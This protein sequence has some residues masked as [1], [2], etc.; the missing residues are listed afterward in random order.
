MIKQATPDNI[1]EATHLLQKGELV[2]FPT[3]TV[4]GL[5]ADATSDQAVEK[6]YAVKNRPRDKAFAIMVHDL[7]QARSLAVFD[8][9]A[10]TLAQV[11]WPG[12]LS[13]VLPIKENSGLSKTAL[14]GNDTIS[15][16]MPKHR[17]AL[18]LL[19]AC[20]TPLAVPSA[21]SSGHLS[22]TTALDVARDLGDKVG[23]IL[24]DA[25]PVIGIESTIID[26]TR[27][28]AV[29]LRLG[30]V[31]AEEIANLIGE[32]IIAD[33]SQNTSIRLKTELRLKAVDVKPGEAFLGFGNVNYIGVQGIG[34]I[35]DMPENLWRNL[36]PQG[37][38]HEAA[39]CL[40]TM[41]QALDEAGAERIAVQSIPEEGLGQVINDRL[42][43]IGS[44]TT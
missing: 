27:T 35:K 1:L 24:A 32:V 17:I 8:E 36:S 2:A 29:I 31:S 37:D 30:A 15:L 18:D 43:R 20:N 39:A 33:T 22:A 25:T 4:F 13:M 19:K 42:R 44:K 5:G 12:P 38:L 11:Y 34:F 28:P 9:R 16:R 23:L 14:A 40:Y 21:N 41:L 3:E 10:L 7:E 6:L 26:L